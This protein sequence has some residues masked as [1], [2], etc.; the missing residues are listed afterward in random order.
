MSGDC[1]NGHGTYQSA[2]GA[3][4]F[5]GSWRNGVPHGHG[6][7]RTPDGEYVGE[8]K[9]GLMDG[10]GMHVWSNGARYVGLWKNDFRHGNGAMS[11]TDGSRYTGQ[12]A[13]GQMHGA[14]KASFKDGSKYEGDWR[15]GS[16]DGTGVYTHGYG[17]EESDGHD[18]SRF[19]DW[20]WRGVL[21]WAPGA[22]Y[23]GQ[24]RGGLMHGQGIRSFVDG[25]QYEGQ[26]V[27]ILQNTFFR[28]SALH[29]RA[30]AGVSFLRSALHFT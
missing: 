30:T 25:S 6:S 8:L 9:E 2:D 22:R 28:S 1:E 18:E 10:R 15:D 20:K 7:F 23:E 17:A 26:P 29:C 27:E 21:E 3:Y 16:P 4:R 24:W 12:W 13:E 11:W 19:H 5:E 14:G